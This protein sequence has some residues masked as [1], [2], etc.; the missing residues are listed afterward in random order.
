MCFFITIAIPGVETDADAIEVVCRRHSGRGMLIEPTSNPSAVSAATRAEDGGGAPMLVT[1]GGCSCAWYSRPRS[2][3]AESAYEQARVRYRKR[4]WSEAKIE[5]A[6]AAKKAS[7]ER[8]DDPS[9]GLHEVVLELLRAVVDE[10][11]AVSVWVHDFTGKVD[12]EPY[13][14]ARRI[15]CSVSD[16]PRHVRELDTDVLLDVVR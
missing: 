1:G 13:S 12:R 11:G 3:G 9:A 6:L 5:R 4:G 14:I 8:S 15:R 7:R 16:L 10:H 2:A